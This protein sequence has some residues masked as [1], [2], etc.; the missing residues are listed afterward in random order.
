MGSAVG[1]PPARLRKGQ[2]DSKETRKQCNRQDQVGQLIIL[3]IIIHNKNWFMMI[4]TSIVDNN[5]VIALAI[6]LANLMITKWR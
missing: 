3:I 2:W 4:I 1:L 6:R 5:N